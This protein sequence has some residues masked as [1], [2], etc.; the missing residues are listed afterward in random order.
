MVLFHATTENVAV[1]SEDGHLPSFFVP[2]PGDLT[3][4]ESPIPGICHPRQKNANARGSPQEGGGGG[5]LGA[6][7][8]I[9]LCITPEFAYDGCGDL[10]FCSS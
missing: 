1:L 4:Q 7:G 9:D 2:N 6:G 5:G 10:I 3:A 8:G